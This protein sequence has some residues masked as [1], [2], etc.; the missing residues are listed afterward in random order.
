MTETVDILAKWH[1][2]ANIV[3]GI[4]KKELAV[5]GSRV[6]EDYQ[7]DEDSRSEWKE[8]ILEA[9]LLARQVK[10]NRKYAGA[11]VA[12]VKYPI[13]ASS[14]IQFA[15]RAFPSI[16]NGRDVVKHKVVGN[17]DSGIKSATGLRVS[18]HMN[19]QILDQMDEWETGMDTLLACL[20]ITGLYYK[21]IYHYHS[22]NVNQADICSPEEVVVNYW[23]KSFERNRVTHLLEFNENEIIERI[24]ADEFIDFEYGQPIT[25]GKHDENDEDAPHVF[26]EQH[27]TWDL[28]GDG[29]KEPY[30]IT[31]H[32]DTEKVVRIVARWDSDGVI[33]KPT[34]D[35]SLGRLI[36]IKPFNYWVKYGFMPPLDGSWYNTGFG[37]LLGPLNASINTIINQL[38]DAGTLSNR[39]SGFIGNGIKLGKEQKLKFKAGEWKKVQVLGDDLRKNIFPLPVREPS[40]V[41][42]KLLD[43]V[44]MGAKELASQTELLS[45]EQKQH[46][47]PATTTLALIEQGLK[48]FTAVY[49]RIHSSLKKEFMLLRRLNRLYLSDEEYNL[50]LDTPEPVSVFEDYNNQTLDIIPVSDAAEVTDIQ[51]LAKAEALKEFVGSGHVDDNAVVMRILSAMQIP[52]VEELMPKEQEP[53]PELEIK[54]AE[55]QNDKDRIQIEAARHLLEEER[56]IVEKMEKLAKVAKV[57]EDA[58]KA[59]ATGIK[60]LMEAESIEVGPQLEQFQ[61]EAQVMQDAI[62]LQNQLLMEFINGSVSRAGGVRKM[63]IGPGNADGNVATQGQNPIR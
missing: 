40:A 2:M 22:E 44:L 25:G 32:K 12:D 23:A 1:D 17:D 42:F 47:V 33:R 58:F 36:K 37:I 39:Q 51:K 48:V 34:Q 11:D 16:V 61:A 38:I 5:I 62:G 18:Q 59:R 4:K 53:N 41:L 43:L 21:K 15:A 57:N 19:F 60:A 52:D 10:E 7:I 31:V 50:I 6:V 3:P 46:N 45:G 49:K 28:D 63:D 26:L 55:L 30:V 35:G 13:I 14:A 54:M 56:F 29:Y 24:N 27:R 20:P 8:Q 9:L